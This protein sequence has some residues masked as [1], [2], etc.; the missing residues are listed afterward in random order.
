[1]L[2][3]AATLV[4]YHGWFCAKETTYRLY[5]PIADTAYWPLLRCQTAQARDDWTPHLDKVLYK[6]TRDS[7]RLRLGS[8][9]RV[10]PLPDGGQTKALAVESTPVPKPKGLRQTTPTRWNNG[11]WEKGIV[12][13]WVR[14]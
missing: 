1:M 7:F 11:R 12:H 2:T 10:F 5:Q 13:G 9:W 8:G 3:A 4:L 6:E 14:A